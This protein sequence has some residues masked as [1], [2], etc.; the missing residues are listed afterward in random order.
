MIYSPK[1]YV[2]LF[3]AI[4]EHPPE[5]YSF[6]LCLGL[7]G[8]N[9]ILLLSGSFQPSYR[10]IVIRSSFLECAP[11]TLRLGRLRES[12]HYM[13]AQVFHPS[14]AIDIMLVGK[15]SLLT[16]LSLKPNTALRAFV[17]SP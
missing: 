8:V 14:H 2:R 12:D 15:L 3:G 9:V 11:L 4:L 5:I 10:S 1:N 16:I 6:Y 7:P 13:F 17:N